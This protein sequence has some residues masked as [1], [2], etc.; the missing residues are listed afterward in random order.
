MALLHRKDKLRALFFLLK[1]TIVVI[2]LNF[3]LELHYR[4]DSLGPWK[5][6]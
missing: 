3:A 4:F 6:Q 5:L 2:Q 1:E